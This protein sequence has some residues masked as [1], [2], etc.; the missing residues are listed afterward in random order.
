MPLAATHCTPLLHVA[1]IETSIRFYE[2]LGFKVIDTDRCTPLGWA[3][4]HC[5]GGALMF[6]RA[7][8]AIDPAKQAVSFCMY[9]PDLA[10]FCE[11]LKA[12]GVDVP[13]I[14]FPPYMRGGEVRLT[15]P[16]G[17]YIFVNH[18]DEKDQKAW[19]ERIHAGS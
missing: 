19:L 16:D 10:A 17:Y 9:T 13:P 11:Q 6:L 4:I 1:D 7:E 15:D 18:W 2:R 5:E 12:E 3:R 14:S 8:H